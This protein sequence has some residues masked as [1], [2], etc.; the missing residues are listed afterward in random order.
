MS[1]LRL[2]SSS[3]FKDYQELLYYFFLCVFVYTSV[4]RSFKCAHFTSIMEKC[5]NNI[6]RYIRV[7]YGTCSAS[8]ISWC[9][10]SVVKIAVVIVFVIT[11]VGVHVSLP[12]VFM[13]VHSP[14]D[15]SPNVG[16]PSFET[17][18]VPPP[19]CQVVSGVTH[20]RPYGGFK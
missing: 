8:C 20:E 5:T 3:L 12:C 14:F 13:S 16:S 4:C 2:P 9:A 19:R 7:S 15:T 18:S 11:I 10:P 1:I 6:C 17:W